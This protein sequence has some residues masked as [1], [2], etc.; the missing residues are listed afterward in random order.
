MT[1]EGIL[2]VEGERI[3]YLE[4]LK[5]IPSEEALA[6]KAILA[7][8]RQALRRDMGLRVQQLINAQ[9][10][11]FRLSYDG[12]ILWKAATIARIKKGRS[13]LYPSI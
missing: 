8:A 13:V 3:G 6:D 10:N 9:D 2:I 1:A 12:K 11:A 4:G 5:F 7:A